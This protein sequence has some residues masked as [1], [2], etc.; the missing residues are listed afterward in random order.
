MGRVRTAAFEALAQGDDQLRLQ[1]ERD[2]VIERFLE[3]GV[4]CEPLTPPERAKGAKLL[5]RL[6]VA[7]SKH[8]KRTYAKQLRY[9]REAEARH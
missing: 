1:P 8:A 6:A 3:D 4:L 5:I 7:G 9:L 2:R